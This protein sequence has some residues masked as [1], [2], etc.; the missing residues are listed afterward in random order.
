[1]EVGTLC[2]RGVASLNSRGHHPPGGGRRA[3]SNSRRLRCILRGGGGRL[4]ATILAERGRGWEGVVQRGRVCVCKRERGG[5]RGRER[6]RGRGREGA[7]QAESGESRV[8]PVRQRER[9]SE[10]IHVSL[11][12]PSWLVLANLRTTPVLRRNVKRF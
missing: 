1:M 6:E 8:V 7:W 11:Q 10:F 3:M 2:S 9:E 5:K 4:V 12:T